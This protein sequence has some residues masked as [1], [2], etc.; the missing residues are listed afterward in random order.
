MKSSLKY[1]L[2]FTGTCKPG[3]ENSGKDTLVSVK[4]IPKL[5]WC[6]TRQKLN[7]SRY[8]KTDTHKLMLIYELC[9]IYLI[10]KKN[11]GTVHVL[12]TL[13]VLFLCL[14][15]FG[16]WN[17]LSFNQDNSE[18]IWLEF[19]LLLLLLELCFLKRNAVS[20]LGAC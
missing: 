2:Q 16:N 10:F 8:V 11:R 5:L 12:N 15:I 4:L 9:Y 17:E 1:Q 6:E 18:N 14:T 19:D 20:G 7:I 3:L 13:V